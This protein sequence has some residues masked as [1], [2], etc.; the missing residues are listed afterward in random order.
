MKQVITILLLTIYTTF[1][2]GLVVNTHYCGGKVASI[3]AYTTLEKG[4]KFCGSK[5]MSKDCCKD[6]QTQLS[7]DDNQN[8]PQTNVTTPDFSSAFQLIPSIQIVPTPS[9]SVTNKHNIQFYSLDTGPPKTPIY[10][11]LQSL[12]I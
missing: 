5:K 1:N 9:F 3:S 6:S 12:I 7:M 8:G 10:I 11:Q 2:I 4:C